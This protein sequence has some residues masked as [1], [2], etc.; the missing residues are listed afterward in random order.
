[1]NLSDLRAPEGQNQQAK[2]CRPR[3]GLR[4]ARRRAAAHKGARSVSG[5]SL[6]RG[7]EGGQMPLHRRL[8]KRG[9]KNIFRK[10]YAVVNLGRLNEL[11][12]DTFDFDSLKELGVRQEAAG[13]AE[14]PRYGR[15]HAR[16]SPSL[17]TSSP[18]QPAEDR[19]GR[20]QGLVV[21]DAGPNS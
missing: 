13:R 20:R 15:A 14:D 16:P 21:G 1:M 11:E 8:P 12:G 7:F 3:Y 10:E 9:F 4:R 17:P 18:Q 2:A 19:S 6:M 5:Y